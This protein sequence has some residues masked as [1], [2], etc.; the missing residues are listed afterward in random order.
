MPA[1]PLKICFSL[2]NSYNIRENGGDIDICSFLVYFFFLRIILK[3]VSKIPK[4]FPLFEDIKNRK[5]YGKDKPV[6]IK[7]NH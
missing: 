1:M 5:H 7:M 3:K 4:H 6:D 2:K